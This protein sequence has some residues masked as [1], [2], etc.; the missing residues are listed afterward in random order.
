MA[1]YADRATGCLVR[2]HRAELGAH[3]GSTETASGVAAENME[4]KRKCS[5]MLPGNETMKRHVQI[6]GTVWG[7][8]ASCTS[9]KAT[10]ISF[11][12]MAGKEGGPG[13]LP[14]C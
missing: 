6:L 10:L 12:K 14:C 7:L 5:L 2:R 3:Q 11:L 1:A 4:I 9:G 13:L 8:E